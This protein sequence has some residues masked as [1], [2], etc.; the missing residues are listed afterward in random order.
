MPPSTARLAF[1]HFERV[2][3]SESNFWAIVQSLG[4]GRSYDYKA[5]KADLI[6][7]LDEQQ[8]RYFRDIFQRKQS[9]LMRALSRYEED[10]DVEL[11]VS[12]DGFSDLTAHIIGLGRREYNQVMKNPQLG[13]D[14]ANARYGSPDGYKESF[15]YAIPYEDDYRKAKP[16]SDTG[17]KPIDRGITTDDMPSGLASAYRGAVAAFLTALD[18]EE[19]AENAKN[20]AYAEAQK[21]RQNVEKWAERVYGREAAWDW[22]GS[23][24][25]FGE[26]VH[27]QLR[28]KSPAEARELWRGHARKLL[29]QL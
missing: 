29:K 14:R 26:H 25:K 5:M 15:A 22:L 6:K 27:Y 9:E 21:M 13:V 7:R 24:M 28:G 19:A 1:R 3:F 16:V 11:G 4:W 23:S 8:A 2:A 12:D 18:K 17:F 10:E 20:A